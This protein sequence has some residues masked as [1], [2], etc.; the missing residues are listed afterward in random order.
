MSSFFDI[1]ARRVIYSTSDYDG[2][3]EKVLPVDSFCHFLITVVDD[4]YLLV[5]DLIVDAKRAGIGFRNHTIP[6]N[7]PPGAEWD[8][9]LLFIEPEAACTDMNIS[10]QFEVPLPKFEQHSSLTGISVTWLTTAD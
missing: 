5:D 9:D 6:M 2:D 7:A 10:C 8:E 1:Q 3:F 4:D